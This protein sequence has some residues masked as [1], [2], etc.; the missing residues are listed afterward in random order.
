MTL[1]WRPT[2]V[3][4]DDNRGIL[5]ALRRL[6]HPEFE[7]V[8]MVEDGA[9]LLIAA[10]E[11]RPDLIV[12][13]ISMPRMDGFRAA[14]QLR[15]EH[16]EARILFITMHEESSMVTQALALGVAGYVLKRSAATELIP[17]MYRVM[18][19]ETFVS[20][21]LKQVLHEHE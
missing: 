14:K 3:L 13:D 8:G 21:H 20:A 17:A 2:V 7:V 12:T 19:G 5:D 9:A 6:L 11:L 15:R 4:A 1:K 16:P 10:Q 18:H